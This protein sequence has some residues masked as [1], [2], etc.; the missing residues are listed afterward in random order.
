M[1]KLLLGTY[2]V[3]LSYNALYQFNGI[4]SDYLS[5]SVV[6]SL[7]KSLP[8]GPKI[9]L[10]LYLQTIAVEYQIGPQVAGLEEFDSAFDFVSQDDAQVST[11]KW[12]DFP[13][14]NLR[15]A[16]MVF[17]IDLLGDYPS[18]IIP[19][20]EDLSA[21]TYR[22][23]KEE[24]ASNKY[25]NDADQSIRCIL[26]ALLETQMFAVL[27]QARSE[28]GQYHIVFFEYGSNLL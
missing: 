23:F 7:T 14:L 9:R 5:I 1:I 2:I 25:L 4:S 24:F 15:D 18:Y 6:E 28:G 21:D 13:T 27:L 11:K 17:M 22:T 20:I 12:E 19:P 26:E 3:D 16:F 10:Q 8:E